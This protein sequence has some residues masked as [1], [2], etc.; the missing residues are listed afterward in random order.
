MDHDHG[1]HGGGGTGNTT[2][3]VTNEELAQRFWY[4]V[5]GF[6]GAF[7]VCRI[8]NWY[9]LERRLAVI[10]DIST[11]AGLMLTRGT[12]SQ[13]TTAHVEFRPISN[14]TGHGLS[15][16]VGNLYGRGS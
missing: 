13:T 16:A 6:V 4:I 15:R 11:R 10:P 14:K 3:P 9:K 7:L 2:Y 8:I 1:S 12:C 5:A